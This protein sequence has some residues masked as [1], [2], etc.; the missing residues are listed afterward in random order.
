[1]TTIIKPTIGRRVWYWPSDFDR[2]VLQSKPSSRIQASD[3]S[4][5]CDAGI[6]YVH[7][8]RMV[9]LTVADHNGWVHSRC[10]V[11]LLQEGDAPPPAG[12]AYAQWMPYQVG[13]AARHSTTGPKG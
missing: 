7:G 9:N 5:P 6:A 13:Q 12:T 8:D 1:M 4:Q 10:S 3:Q 2:G 11:T